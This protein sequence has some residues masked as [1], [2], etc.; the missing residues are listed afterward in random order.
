MTPLP[1]VQKS[2]PSADEGAARVER[3]LAEPLGE[4]RHSNGLRGPRLDRAPGVLKNGSTISWAGPR[5]GTPAPTNGW[6]NRPKPKTSRRDQARSGNSAV[7][8][9]TD[10]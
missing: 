9:A 7:E 2:P 6:P 8:T 4:P 3:S 1:S 5:E 10:H